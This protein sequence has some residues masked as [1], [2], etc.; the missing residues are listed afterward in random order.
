MIERTIFRE[1]HEIFRQTVR[2]FVDRE[3]VPYAAEWDRREA[4]DRTVV[5]RLGDLGLLGV[6]VPEAYGGVGLDKVSSLVV[7][8]KHKPWHVASTTG[9][10]LNAR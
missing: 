4:I 5:N 2:R 7:S 8:A 1:E 3:I 10:G 6:D 9:R